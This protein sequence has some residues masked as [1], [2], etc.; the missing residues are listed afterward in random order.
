MYNKAEPLLTQRGGA[1]HYAEGS[2]PTSGH[3]FYFKRQL[4]GVQTFNCFEQQNGCY[5]KI[6]V[7][8]GKTETIAAHTHL[9]SCVVPLI[10]YTNM[11][12]AQQLKGHA[13]RLGTHSTPKLIYDSLFKELMNPELTSEHYVANEGYKQFPPFTKIRKAVSKRV[14]GGKAKWAVPVDVHDL[15]GQLNDPVHEG[16]LNIKVNSVDEM[17]VFVRQLPQVPPFKNH[18]IC[19]CLGTVQMMSALFSQKMV[20]VDGT[21]KVVP[22]I[23]YTRRKTDFTRK[24]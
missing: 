5:A 6:E 23:L 11:K 13:I 14:N 9:E 15:V 1:T 22:G 7:Y 19:V 4:K 2:G 24:Q 17:F 3:L 10:R 8:N 12:A 18:E 20:C 16:K 21:F